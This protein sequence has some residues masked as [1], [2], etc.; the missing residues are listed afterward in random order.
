MYEFFG[1]YSLYDYP[2]T[3]RRGLLHKDRGKNR[4]LSYVSL[5]SLHGREIQYKLNKLEGEQCLFLLSSCPPAYTA[6]AAHG[7]MTN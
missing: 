7:E 1:A 3:P 5:D 6:D 4:R 2:L